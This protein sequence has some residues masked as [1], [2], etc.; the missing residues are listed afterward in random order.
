MRPYFDKPE[1]LHALAKV[2]NEWEGTPYAHWTG[3]KQGGCDCIHFVTRVLEELG[4]DTWQIPWYPKDW[5]LH[6]SEELLLNGMKADPNFLEVD[7]DAPE[8]GDIVLFKFGKTCSHS[9]FYLDE[10]VYQ[11]ITDI[12]VERRHWQDPQWYKRRRHAFRVMEE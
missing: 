8:D 7:V 4:V 5:N 3:V 1:R 10:H 9:G 11:A 12:G 2:L 6:N